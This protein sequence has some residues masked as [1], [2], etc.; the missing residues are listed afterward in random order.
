MLVLIPILAMLGL[1]FIIPGERKLS[2]KALCSMIVLVLLGFIGMRSMIPEDW[3][4]PEADAVTRVCAQIEHLLSTKNWQRKPILILEGTSATAYGVNGR[5]LE[6]LLAAQGVDVT[7]LQFSLVGANHF[8]RLWM[9][10][11]F[12]QKMGTEHREEMKHAPTILLSEVFDAYDKEPLYLFQKEA[13][14]HRAITW[15]S[16]T[17]VIAAW[18]A[19]KKYSWTLFEHLLFNRFAVGIF[20]SMQ[21]PSYTKKTEGFF[22]LVGT[23]KTFCY[24]TTS[25]TF[26]EVTSNYTAEPSPEPTVYD[27]PFY[28]KKLQQEFGNV[29]SLFGFYALPTLEMQRRAYQVAFAKSLPI[30][31]IMLG[32]ASLIVMKNLNCEKN[33][34]DGVHPQ[35][36]GAILFTQWLAQEICREMEKLNLKT[37]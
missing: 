34:F 28:E 5:M 15:A 2:A 17:I 13:Y 6:K 27:T 7:V 3:I 21:P 35:R 14:S 20:A 33:W 8:E 23:K 11:L 24:A 32:P 18:K 19:A 10:N 16:P 12:F 1:K 22:P 25:K 29:I 9:L 36:E 37:L 26:E 30:T 31:T 4:Y